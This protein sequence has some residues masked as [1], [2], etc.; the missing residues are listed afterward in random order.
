MNFITQLGV[1]AVILMILVIIVKSNQTLEKIYME[2]EKEEKPK[3]E[4]P[5]I[6]ISDF[7]L[8]KKE[9]KWSFGKKEKEVEQ[10][11]PE[12]TMKPTGRS[13]QTIPM[14]QHAEVIIEVLDDRGR[15]MQKKK[16]SHFPFSIGRNAENDLVLD[17][18]S[19][20]GFHA[21]LEKE[22]D[23]IIL[24]DQGS[25]NKLMVFGRQETKV[26]I[27]GQVEVGFGNTTLR[28]FKEKKN[29]RPTICYDGTSLMEEW[30]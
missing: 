28:F 22:E 29:D 18:L 13:A 6:K 8:P 12:K 19:V 21:C 11:E 4:I 5:Q 27:N 24:V 2:E 7:K 1:L 15:S 3:E 16:V 25:L 9:G 23:Q 14:E 26:F 30:R 17:D 20:S 10:E